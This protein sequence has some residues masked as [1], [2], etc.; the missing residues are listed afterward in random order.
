[1]RRLIPSVLLAGLTAVS[2]ATVWAQDTTTTTT[3]PAPKSE[4]TV[5]TENRGGLKDE[6]VGIKP[7]LGFVNF[8]DATGT[9]TNRGAIGLA[10][11]MNLARGIAGGP[12]PFYIGFS[13]GGLYSHLGEPG[14]GFFGTST[15]KSSGFGGA[16]LVQVPVDAK[17]GYSVTDH[18]RI[19]AHGGGNVMYCSIPSAMGTNLGSAVDRKWNIFPNVGGDV[20]IG[21]GRNFALT[22][23]PDWTFTPGVGFFTGVAELGLALG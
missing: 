22:L 21:L 13:T 20:D 12:T 14:S 17:L 15:A 6:A 2:S 7:S 9:A 19:S 23:R 4:T 1:M 10:Y 8:K 3:T 18:L 5:S 11:D 16:N